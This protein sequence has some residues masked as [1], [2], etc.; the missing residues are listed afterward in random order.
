MLSFFTHGLGKTSNSSPKRKYA[1]IRSKKVVRSRNPRTKGAEHVRY[2]RPEAY[3]LVGTRDVD[4]DH[5]E[6]R[7]SREGGRGASAVCVYRRVD[8]GVEPEETTVQ[9]RW[10]M[11]HEYD[12]RSKQG[13]RGLKG[14]VDG[15]G[16][17][18]NDDDAEASGDERT[19]L[20]KNNKVK[21]KVESKAPRRKTEISRRE[22]RTRHRN[23]LGQSPYS[24][25]Q[26]TT[27][28]PSPTLPH[29]SAV[30]SVSNS[31]FASRTSRQ[32][33]IR[34]VA[35]EQVSEPEEIS[36]PR[37]SDSMSWV[38]PPPRSRPVDTATQ[39]R[40]PDH[41]TPFEQPTMSS[42]QSITFVFGA[43]K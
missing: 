21:V 38:P 26:K 10:T 18:E 1:L 20:I 13:Y 34:H 41:T 33:P 28:K 39:P 30:S 7:G 43:T 15:A 2:G 27:S 9:E 19:K 29:Q 8:D 11:R 35:Y 37:T 40:P 42:E 36:S 14:K 31:A 23:E 17:R 6:G 24:H 32:G 12:P 3:Q 25:A 4:D 5:D 16:G 22:H